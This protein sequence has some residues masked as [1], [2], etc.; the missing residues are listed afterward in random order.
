[1]DNNHEEELL[2]LMN[3][4]FG[5]GAAAASEKITAMYPIPGVQDNDSYGCHGNQTNS[6]SKQVLQFPLVIFS[7]VQMLLRSEK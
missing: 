3:E 7:S 1:M 5:Y 2:R 6:R 4:T